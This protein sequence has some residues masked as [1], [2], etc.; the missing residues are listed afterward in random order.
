MCLKKSAFAAFILC[1]A[2]FCGCANN[3]EKEAKAK[4]IRARHG[5]DSLQ[6]VLQ[7]GLNQS[8]DER[9]ET[10]MRLIQSIVDYSVAYP[11]DTLTPDYLFRRAQLFETGLN[12]AR[13][14]AELLDELPTKYPEYKNNAIALFLAGNAW[15]AAGDT[16]N[17]VKSLKAFKSKYP[18]HPW[19]S[20][21]DGLLRFMQLSNKE[22]DEFFKRT[23]PETSGDGTEINDQTPKM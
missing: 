23:Q 9:T 13:R 3:K 8:E 22:Q 17:A 14:S 7:K 12:D 15:Q 16:A 20:Q 6:N 5:V 11:K 18:N 2:L 1:L 10:T 21:A 19:M 4:Q